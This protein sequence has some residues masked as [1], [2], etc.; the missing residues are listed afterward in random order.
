[1]NKRI[2]VSVI[3]HFAFLWVAMIALMFVANFV[4]KA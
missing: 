4:D 2:V 3:A 1:M